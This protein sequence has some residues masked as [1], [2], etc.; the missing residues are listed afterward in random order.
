MAFKF[1]KRRGQEFY[2][3]P[4]FP[5]LLILCVVEAHLAD[6]KG[7]VK[8]SALISLARA[9][10]FHSCMYSLA[11][12]ILVLCILISALSLFVLFIYSFI[13]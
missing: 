8:S 6:P 12:T 5:E 4:L 10:I 7:T 13:C 11:T 3:E 1:T 2:Q 9:N